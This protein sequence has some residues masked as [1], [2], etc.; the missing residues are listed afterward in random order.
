[1]KRFV[2]F[3]LCA[4]FML[5]AFACVKQTVPERPTESENGQVKIYDSK[6][7]QPDEKA[8]ENKAPEAE[9][10]P[11]AEP[12]KAEE[13][14]EEP[15]VEATEEPAPEVTEEPKTEEQSTEEPAPIEPANPATDGEYT[16]ENAVDGK[17][18]SMENPA[19][20][21]QWVKAT[22]Y[23]PTSGKN[24][25]A[26][27]RIVN[28]TTDCQADIDAYTGFY[29]LDPIEQDGLSYYAATYE[30]YFPE[31]WEVPEWGI[32][33]PTISL[34]ARN[35]EGGGYTLNGL[36][37]IGLGHCIDMNL[38]PADKLMPGQTYTGKVIYTMLTEEPHYVFEYY[39][40]VEG[41]EGLVY[42]YVD[43]VR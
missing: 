42:S 31:D 22:R 13:P 25:V 6:D 1:M 40:N 2:C 15:A 41:A 12:E 27:W 17:D 26:Y 24:D 10:Q 35:P 37:I 3:M 29:K 4:L 39:Y 18:T 9:Q 21:G 36:T 20:F 28:I 33:S 16:I 43:N 8:E 23:N 14:K 30:V 34:S 19:K 5:S 38:Q 7:Q 11:E 32:S